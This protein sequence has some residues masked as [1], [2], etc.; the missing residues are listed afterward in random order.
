MLFI[1]TLILIFPIMINL[2]PTENQ[3]QLVTDFQDLVSTPFQGE[4]NAICWTRELQGDFSEIVEKV[5]LEDNIAELDE[6]DLRELE[7]SEQGQ[8]AREILL[9]DL[10]LLKAHGASP[11]LNVIK[12]YERDDTFPFFP[13]D[14]YSFHVDRS[15]VPTSTFLCTYYGESSEILPN[16][17]AIQKILVPE[18]RDELKKLY[19]GTDE[20]FESFL[21][22]HFFDLHYQAKSSDR[23]IILGL[24]HVWRLAVDYPNS[25]VL[26][27]LHRAPKEKTGQNRLLMIC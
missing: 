26:P 11:I 27:C 8:L 15:P 25:Q 18:I 19:H 16:S 12:Y 22:E 2:S 23:P 7:L 5:A 24:G 20:G 3:I 21:R 10:K 6:E 14:V 17:Q 9:N 4:T 13:T 1:L